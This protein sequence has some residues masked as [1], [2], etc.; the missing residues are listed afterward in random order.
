MII[1]SEEMQSILSQKIAIITHKLTALPQQI[2]S[3]SSSG[4]SPQPPSATSGSSSPLHSPKAT[5]HES[6]KKPLEPSR[7]EPGDTLPSPQC[8][9]RLSK[10]E[11]P[12]YSGDPLNWQSFWDCFE[13]AIHLNPNL[14]GV[15]KLS[16]LRTQLEGEAARVITGLPLTNTNYEHSVDLLK[17]RYGQPD[18]LIKAHIQALLDTPRPVNKLASLLSFHDTIE[19]HIRC[20]ESL[21]KSPDSLETLLVP[22][23]LGKLPEETK[24]NM[25]RAHDSSEWTVDELQKA[26]IKEIQIFEAGYQT[27]HSTSQDRPPTA[28]FFTSTGK[29]SSQKPREHTTKQ[30]MR[31]YCKGN[32][33]PTNCEVHEDQQSRIAIIKQEKLCF[34]CLAHHRV[35]QCS[36][37]NR[38][39]KCNG[40]HHTSICN[41]STSTNSSSS[42]VASNNSGTTSSDQT[43]PP[44][45]SATGTDLITSLTTL[46][47]PQLT[48]NTVCLL[49]TTITTVINGSI[50]AE[51][52]IL[53][54]EG[55]Q[56]PFLTEQLTH[57]LEVVPHNSEHIS[58]TS[59]GSTKPV[60]RCLDNVIINLK[61]STGDLMP[62]S[63]LVVPNIAAPLNNTV[64]TTLSDVSY[65]KGLPLA[66]PVSSA[67]N[68]EIS[69]LVGADFYWNFIGDH[70][71][72]GDGPTAVS[73]RLGYVL[74]GPL[75]VPQS[76]YSV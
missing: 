7:R 20:L 74:S 47:P 27:S 31:T 53:F 55:S 39:R 13:S 42:S 16:Y 41:S 43:Q 21:G 66:H 14:C 62:I 9:T 75:S 11:V 1:D 51:A 37:R 22:I 34:N 40:K 70:V 49:K 35:S 68:F 15:Q 48:R 8:V 56:R 17:G 69:L 76:H 2:A 50:Q 33:T 46:V 54:D 72:R 36:S 67:E 57:L 24:K 61:T 4:S 6:S 30:P 3:D 44:S 18:K 28:S 52:N 63:A 64:R 32:H 58:L 10:L 73:S 12:K 29:K 25:A 19:G 26:I 65:L 5:H 45:N 23:M 38:C 71:V 59:F 60:L